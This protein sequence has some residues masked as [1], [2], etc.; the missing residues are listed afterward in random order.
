MDDIVINMVPH[1]QPI[2]PTMPKP[3]KLVT[4]KVTPPIHD[5][6]YR[7]IGQLQ[8]EQKR[9]VTASE[10]IAAL[11]ET[12][13]QLQEQQSKPSELPDSLNEEG[14]QLSVRR[15]IHGRGRLPKKLD[16]PEQDGIKN[17]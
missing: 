11:L 5:E 2:E 13:K 9:R 15:R 12:C 16:N 8:W 10:A 6:L 1:P 7:F 17:S 14:G 3:K 4:L